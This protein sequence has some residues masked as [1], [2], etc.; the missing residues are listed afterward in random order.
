MSAELHINSETPNFRASDLSLP[1]SASAQ[2]L[3][4]A[5]APIATLH[6]SDLEPGIDVYQAGKASSLQTCTANYIRDQYHAAHGATLKTLMYSRF[7]ILDKQQQPTAVIGVK[8]FIN[9]PTLVEKYLDAPIEQIV[10]KVIARQIRRDAIAEV[11]NL[12]AESLIQSCRLIVFLI[13]Y[14]SEEGISHGVCTGTTAVRLALKRA[15]VPFITIGDAD[16]ERLGEE[17]WS[18][19]TY[20]NNTPKVLLIDI[21]EGLAAVAD[22]YTYR[23]RLTDINTCTPMA[24]NT[25]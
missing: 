10:S 8:R 3:S 20:Y 15:R 22:R 21:Q 17:Q 14:L 2:P 9:Q 1:F 24:L 18:W 11:G 25:Q 19:G 23:R 4:V 7:A 13:N 12:A 16:P 6:Y 5:P